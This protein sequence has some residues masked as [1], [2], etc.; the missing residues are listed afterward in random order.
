MSEI[1]ERYA[2]N[3]RRFLDKVAAVPADRWDAPTPCEG[4]TARDLV[5][6]VVDSQGLFLRLVGREQAELPS[7]QD[8]PLAA[9]SGALGQVQADLEDPG[10][11]GATFE[12]LFGT[13]TFAQGVDRFLTFDLVVHGWDLARATGQ[14]DAI[15]PDELDRIEAAAQE[16]DRS[17]AMR[18][19]NAFGPALPAPDGADQQ[20][21][22]LAFLGRTG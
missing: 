16:M 14:D 3:A 22:L 20:A 7:C 12:G 11:A 4:W 6:H 13:Q 19:P 5:Q 9:A 15:P 2:R 8:D 18:G 17:G 21:R 10:A 1:S